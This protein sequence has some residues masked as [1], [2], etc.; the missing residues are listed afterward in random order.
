MLDFKE[1]NKVFD[2]LR[3]RHDTW[4]IFKDFLNIVIDNFTIPDETP[5]F[6]NDD[7]YND[8]EINYFGELFQVYIQSMQKIL[9]KKNYCDFLG[10]WWESDQNMTNKFKAQFFT[11][12]NV[13]ELM[14]DLTVLPDGED[15]VKVMTDCCC[16]S[17]RFGIVY[18][19]KRPYDWFF[20]ADLDEYAVKMTIVNMLLHGMRGVVAWQNTLTEEVFGVWVVSPDLLSYGG[21]PYVVPYGTDL[22]GALALLPKGNHVEAQKPEVKQVMETP[23]KQEIQA[24]DDIGGLDKWMK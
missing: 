9:E 7:K 17:G 19:D 21:L 22:E 8:D 13:C 10:E 11:P 18:H 12:M 20:L 5:M 24:D 2:Y 23:S 4:Y 15:D 3:H 6:K 14:T 1:W 16:G